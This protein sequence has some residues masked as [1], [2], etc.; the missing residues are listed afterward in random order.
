MFVAFVKGLAVGVEVVVIA[1]VD[2]LA[3][4]VVESPIQTCRLSGM[5]VVIT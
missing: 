3:A 1:E 2:R 4:D 5:G